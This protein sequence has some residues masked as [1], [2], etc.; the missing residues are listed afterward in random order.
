[1]SPD[2]ARLVTA[3]ATLDPDAQ[4]VPHRAV[5]GRP[6]GRRPAPAADPRRKGETAPRVPPRRRPAVHLRPARPRRARTTTDAPP[7]SGCCP[8]AAARPGWWPPGPAASTRRLARD[9]GTVVVFG[10]DAARRPSPAT[11]T[12]S[13]ARP[14]RSRKVS[15]I[16]HERLPGALLGPRPRPGPSRG[17]SRRGVDATG[18]RSTWRDLTPDAGRGA[19]RGRL[20]RHPGRPT[21]VATWRCPS[22][23]RA[24]ARRWWRSTSRPASGGCCST[25]RTADVRRRPPSRPDGTPGGLHPARR[26]AR[27]TP[28]RT[29]PGSSSALDGGERRDLARRLGPLAR[30]TLAGRPTARRSIVTADEHGRRPVFRVDVADRRGHPAHRR[31]RRLLRPARRARRPLR[32]RA[33]QRVDAPPAPGPAR[34]DGAGPASR[35]RLPGPRRRAAAARHADRGHRDRRRTARRC[36]PGC[37]CPRRG[38]RRRRRCCSGSTAARWARGTP[39]VA[40]EPVADG[41]ARLRRAAAR[42]RAVHRLRPRLRPPRLGRWGDA[43][44]RRPDGDHRRR[45]GPRRTSTRRGPPR[46]AARSAATWPTGSP[47][48]PTGSEAIVT[49]ASLWA[50]DQ[51]GRTTDAPTTGAREMTPEMALGRTARTGTSDAITHADAGHP[52]RQ[53]LPGADRRGA[54]AV[55]GAASRPRRDAGDVPHRFLYFPDE[56]HWILKPQ[57]AVVWYETVLAFLGQH[58]LGRDWEVPDLLAGLKRRSRHDRVNCG[59][60]SRPPVGMSGRE[61]GVVGEVVEGASGRRGRRRAAGMGPAGRGR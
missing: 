19:R 14:A 36:A 40:L 35:R 47:A 39:G 11:T 44:V 24:A 4:R 48:T 6:R 8:P 13:A 10:P 54:A 52:R 18:G 27:P 15:A 46:W 37:R 25:T 38:R 7:R 49:H 53:G 30:R 60:G 59:V 21:V 28:P 22:A 1:M 31:R 2:G 17:C 56:N 57:H 34:R 9:A 45:A 3:V 58:V 43:P 12:R 5:G 41:R 61:V 26:A 16:L 20:R 50:L 29:D 51:F 23:R 32:L 55:V 42:P 33:A